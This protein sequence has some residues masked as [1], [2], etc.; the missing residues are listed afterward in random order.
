MPRADK[1]L[2]LQKR[3]RD[4]LVTGVGG[5]GVE[6]NCEGLLRCIRSAPRS[7]GGGAA[8]EAMTQLLCDGRFRFDSG[9]PLGM[10]WV[11]AAPP[12]WLGEAVRGPRVA[13]KCRR[14]TV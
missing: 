5:F 10:A 1:R 4:D 6:E 13:I 11:G 2:R 12:R 3:R 9:T 8:R 7:P 14:F